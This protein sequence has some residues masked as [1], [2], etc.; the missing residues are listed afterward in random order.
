MPPRPFPTLFRLVTRFHSGRPR[1]AGFFAVLVLALL[2][3]V[4]LAAPASAAGTA[5]ATARA[6]KKHHKK[7]RHPKPKPMYWGA[8]I[9]EQFTGTDAPWDMNAVALFQQVIGGKGL[10]LLEFSSPFEDCTRP[11][12]RFYKFPTIAMN[13]VR[14]YGALPVFS[15]GAESNPRV[16]AE[17]PDFQLAD[18]AG[19]AYDAEIAQF[20]AEARDWGHPF[21]LRFSWEMNGNWFPWSEK[22]NGN[23]PGQY[24]AA[25]RRVHDIFGAVG[26]HNA[27]W[28]WCPYADTPK[29]LKQTPLKPLYPGHGYVDWTCLDGYNWGRNPVNPRP[30]RSFDEIFAPAYEAVTKKIAPRKPLML[31]EFA[32]SPYG[33][34]KAL[35]IRKMFEKLPRKYPR[36][37]ALIYFNS[38]DRGVDWPLETSAPAARAFARG[39]HK[40]IYANNRFGEIATSPIPPLR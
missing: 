3:C 31:A 5:D 36:V 10:S 4:L 7:K 2:G 17:Q 20:A 16:S 18:I 37:R 40:G 12:C 13:N 9:G 30:W 1:R 6:G 21:F 19:G 14:A 28:V 32:T 27:T 15:W 33:G 22:A 25:W 24:V 8:W 35:W 29:R 11:P 39:I 23:A 38:V 34:H 26:A